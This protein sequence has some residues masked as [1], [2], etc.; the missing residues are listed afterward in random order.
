[1]VPPLV[2]FSRVRVSLTVR[3]ATFTGMKRRSLMDGSVVQALRDR[4]WARPALLCLV[5]VSLLLAG[6]ARP[7]PDPEARTPAIEVTTKAV[8][9]APP[10]VVPAAPPAPS[11]NTPPA[12]S[13][14]PRAGARAVAGKF[15]VV[16]SV[17]AHATRAG[18]E[19]LDKGGNAADAAVAVAYALAVTHPNAGNLGGGGFLLYRPRGG[20]TTVVDFREKAPNGVTQEKFAQMLAHGAVGPA[21][22][23]VPGSVAGLNLASARFGR[24]PRSAVIAPAIALA[25]NGFPLGPFQARALA[26]AWPDLSKDAAARVIFG[27]GG[28]GKA[29]KKAGATVVQP[30]LATTLERIS[31]RGDDGFY[32]GE[33]ANALAALASSGGLITAAD[34]AAYHAVLREPIAVPYRGFTVEVPPPPSAG[35]FAV[36][37]ELSLFARLEPKPLPFL[38]TDETHLFAEVARRAHAIR[39]FEIGDPDTNPD[40]DVNQKKTEWLDADRVLARFPPIDP[41][42]ATPSS[43]VHPLYGA[44]VAEL[45]HTT[46]LSVVDAE[47]NAASLTTTLSASFGA[48]AMAAGFLLNNAIAAFGTVGKNVLSP[49]RHMTTSMSPAL[50]LANG[51]PVLVVGSPG[52]DTIPNT[53]VR[54]I[55][56]SIDYGMTLEDA[57]DAPRIHHGMV[58]DEIRY[59][60]TRAP[61]KAVLAELRLLGHRVSKPTRSIGDANSIAIVD[62]IPYGYADPREGGLSLAATSAGPG[63]RASPE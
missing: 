42:H 9:S 49:G 43:A 29:P 16:S 15:G 57:V 27:V 7:A 17:E 20:P 59:E 11:T 44:A 33:T 53:V 30:A 54:V 55:R 2:S 52:G 46:H 19:I 45:E 8:T 21:A 47:G 62:G 36:A 12:P 6:C 41:R 60:G 32:K 56:N 58:P 51:N 1:M 28:N 37:I 26:A 63:D 39:R 34:L 5:V 61:P 18:T 14:L 35:G 10:A 13:S 38:S 40:F 31:E 25:R 24:L 4:H 22:A 3:T 48:R 23:A 50:V